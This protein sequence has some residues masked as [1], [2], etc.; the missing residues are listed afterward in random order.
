MLGRLKNGAATLAGLK[1]PKS[2]R[3]AQTSIA[4][5]GVTVLLGA[6]KT[7]AGLAFELP[8]GRKDFVADDALQGLDLEAVGVL[9]S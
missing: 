1:C 6:F 2:A 3:L 9:K 8:F 7:T 4:P 5:F